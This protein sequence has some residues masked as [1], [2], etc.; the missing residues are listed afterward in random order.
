MAEGRDHHV[1]PVAEEILH[2]DRRR[3]VTDRVR[4]RIATTERE[5]LIRSDLMQEAV[6]VTRVPVGREIE[7]PPAIREDGDV[8]I[9]PVVEE[10][11]V[12]ET[13]LVLKE[14]IHIRRIRTVEPTETK[15]TLRTEEAVVEHLGPG[16]A[17][18][19]REG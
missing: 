4:V 7:A 13:R 18:Y 19:P 5:E 15:V 11:L 6:E 1:L 3:V 9:V 10:V 17:P 12:V 16:D 14:E 8:T 2:V